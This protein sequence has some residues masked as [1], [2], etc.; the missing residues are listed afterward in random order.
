MAS[1]GFPRLEP[2]LP[3]VTSPE[4]FRPPHAPWIRV[5]LDISLASLPF[6]ALTII[7]LRTL[8][9]SNVDAHIAAK[10]LLAADRGRPEF[11]GFIYP[12]LPFALTL[13]YP[14][15]ATPAVLASLAGGAT[16]W[17]VWQNLAL[18]SLHLIWRVLLVIG[19]FLAPGVVFSFT[20]SLPDAL[21][22]YLV[23]VGWKRCLDFLREGSTWSGFVAGMALG[24]AFYV[25]YYALLFAL[26]FAGI[27]PIF[28]KN[29]RLSADRAPWFHAARMLVI[30]FPGLWSFISWSYLN[31]AFKGNPFA[32]LTDPATPVVDPARVVQSFSERAAGV[33]LATVRELVSQPLLVLA[34]A[35]NWLQSPRLVVP[36]LAVVA[37][38]LSARLLGLYYGEPLVLAT[39]TVV[40]ILALPRRLPPWS[41]PAVVLVALL[42]SAFGA[43]ILMEKHHE[44]VLWRNA[45]TGGSPRAEDFV[46]MEIARHLASAPPRSILADDRSAYRLLARA[47][48][49]RPFL[50]PADP[51]FATALDHP[52]GSVHYVLVATAPE[53]GDLITARFAR[54]VPSGFT[55][56]GRWPSWT[57][58]RRADVPPLVGNERP[59]KG[60]TTQLPAG[61]STPCRSAT[62]Y[63]PHI[64]APTGPGRVPQQEPELHARPARWKQLW[65]RQPHFLRY[66]QTPPELPAWADDLRR[67][68]GP[69]PVKTRA[70]SGQPPY[71]V[72][73]LRLCI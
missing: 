29:G 57:L 14:H 60:G 62:V 9:V 70:R 30:V 28:G 21:A 67:H 49:A 38:P 23:I 3:P 18:T 19:V 40:A 8:F 68:R 10:A 16:V 11:I 47:G 13:L 59:S 37:V 35:L 39:Y 5:L 71:L 12:P 41:G 61:T 66:A 64:P 53:S 27:I 32:Y 24:L 48:T 56:D 73:P 25:N 26:V 6:L 50:L 54:D 69:P 45:V 65:P 58:Y 44:L 63:P 17:F 4:G 55:L 31:W 52:A 22:L 15:V 33:L 20:Q 1:A 43:G 42:Q 7:G 51:G 36:L 72:A 2:P 34:G 46:E